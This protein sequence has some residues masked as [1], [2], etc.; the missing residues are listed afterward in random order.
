MSISLSRRKLLAAFLTA[1]AATLL[2]CGGGFGSSLPKQG[3]VLGASSPIGHQLRN[4]FRPQPAGN[5]WREHDVVIVGGGMAGLSAAWR[6]QSLGIED[7]VVL[8]LEPRIG[9][10]SASGQAELARY[11]WGAHYVPAPMAHN[12][13]LVALFDELGLIEEFD[14]AG[15]PIVGEQ[16]LCRDPDERLFVN[17]TWHEGLYPF[18]GED[19]A[20]W[21]RFQEEIAAWVSWRD[22]DG[23]RAFTL[24]T[25]AC[26][27]A[28]ELRALDEQTMADWMTERSFDSPRLQWLV[29]Y[30][31]KDDYGLTV[32]QTSAWAGLFYFASRVAHAGG[33]PQALVTFPEGNG[34][35]I[36]HFEDKLDGKIHTGMAVSEIRPLG[37]PGPDD[38]VEPARPYRREVIAVSHDG[39]DVRGYRAR[40]V[41]FAAPQFLAPYLIADLPE[42]RRQATREFEYGVWMV[43]NLHLSNRPEEDAFPLAWD[44]VLYDSKSLGYVVATHQRNLEYG[45]TILTYYH[46]LCDDDP[47]VARQRLLDLSWEDCAEIVMADLQTAHPQI[48]NLTTQL[49][50]MKW[51][52]AM[53]RP[54]PGFFFGPARRAAAR[55][56]D[57]V[58][59]ANTD[60]SGVAL[61]EEA[62]HHGVRAAEEVATANGKSFASLIG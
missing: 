21:D 10:T 43:A 32:E 1:P 4:G 42:P 34:R 8:E 20:Q 11:P 54:R 37:S 12:R 48:R 55:P 3:S 18:F 25:A 28:E 15:E 57:G 23:R 58:H 22:E 13:A 56:F 14:D 45:P 49:D 19:R 16:F 60:L 39:S 53:I 51:G 30:C 5:K 50:V 38:A 27:H 36:R 46:P 26:S 59:F 33:D 24:P 62:L 17:G 44:N 35:F 52:H 40:N 2:G 6:L 9:G 7:I 29:N 61:M 47:S 41:I 31:C